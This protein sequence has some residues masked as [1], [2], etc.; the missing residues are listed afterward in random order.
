MFKTLP[1]ELPDLKIP[2]ALEAVD[3]ILAHADSAILHN[4]GHSGN[5]TAVNHG[6]LYAS[7]RF[8]QPG[9]QQY[10]LERDLRRHLEVAQVLHGILDE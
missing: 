7:A 6:G 1:G 10:H 4:I 8:A 5:A 9:A 3:G 2:G